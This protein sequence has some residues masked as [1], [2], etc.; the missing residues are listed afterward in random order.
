MEILYNKKK[1]AEFLYNYLGI[2]KKD[3]VYT[4]SE[5]GCKRLEKAFREG[6]LV[7][8]DGTGLP[9]CM[10]IY[11][12]Q[13]LLGSS[14]SPYIITSLMENIG[15]YVFLADET[16]SIQAILTAKPDDRNTS[17]LDISKE[18]MSPDIP[19]GY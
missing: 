15:K 13:D 9:V 1:L 3:L 12:G 8:Q 14:E 19:A 17:Q 10:E 6:R 4:Y 18:R 16:G 7:E 11:K 2:I 5:E